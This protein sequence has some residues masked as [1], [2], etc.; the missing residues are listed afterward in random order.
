MRVI[1]N[2]ASTAAWLAWLAW[3]IGLDGK[4]LG[5][6]LHGLRTENAALVARVQALED[7]IAEEEDLKRAFNEIKEL[8]RSEALH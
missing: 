5:K 7:E 1:F 8:T 6:E 3:Q 4:S 2:F